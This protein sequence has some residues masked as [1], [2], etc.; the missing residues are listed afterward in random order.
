MLRVQDHR[1]SVTTDG[2]ETEACEVE[3][4]LAF[5]E[6]FQQRYRVAPVEGLPRFNGGLVGYFGYDSVRYVER[7]LGSCPNPDPLGTPDIL[8][9]VSD[10]VV[11]FDNL[12][13]KLHCIVLVDPSQPEAYEAGQARLQAL[14]AKLRQSITPRLGLISKGATVPSRPSAPAS[15]ARIT[16]RRSIASR[17]TSSPATACRW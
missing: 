9:M 13:G 1:I 15:A 10:A 11:V 4:P 5:V 17:T 8:L 16:S 7:K 3:D 14:R 12:A 6:S 2:V